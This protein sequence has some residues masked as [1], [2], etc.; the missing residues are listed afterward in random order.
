MLGSVLGF[1]DLVKKKT[2]T[3]PVVMKLNSPANSAGKVEYAQRIGRNLK[4][5]HRE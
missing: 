1:G 5:C 3:V 4:L 2:D